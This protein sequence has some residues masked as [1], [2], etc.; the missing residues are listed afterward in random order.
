MVGISGR[1]CLRGTGETLGK[2][3]RLNSLLLL[4]LSLLSLLNSLFKEMVMARSGE[5]SGPSQGKEKGKP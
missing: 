5:K 2:R 4:L 3:R 1:D